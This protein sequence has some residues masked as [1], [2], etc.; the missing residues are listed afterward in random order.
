MAPKKRKVA[1]ASA[2]AN[3]QHVVNPDH[4]AVLNKRL[5]EIDAAGAHPRFCSAYTVALECRNAE[6]VACLH[7]S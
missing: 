5:E 1:A 4:I 2:G 3:A 6:G 7:C